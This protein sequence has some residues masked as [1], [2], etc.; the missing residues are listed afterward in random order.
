[1]KDRYAHYRRQL[2]GTPFPYAVVDM[3]LLRTNA[4]RII[5]R[6]A[7]MPV[8][9]ATKSIRCPTLLRFILEYHPTFRGLMCYDGREADY[10][11]QNGFDDIL[12]GY[13]LVERPVM[14]RLAEWAKRGRRIHFMADST[15]HLDL[16]EAAGQA[17]DLELTACLDID[18]SDR[19][20]GLHFGVWRSPLTDLRKTTTVAGHTRQLRYVRISGVMG[21]E[22]QVA[23]VGDA[24]AGQWLQNRVVRLLQRRSI[25]RAAARRCAVVGELRRM[26]YQ[27]DLV[28]GGGTGSME[29]TRQDSSVTELTAGSGFLGGT[30][31]DGYRG[32]R[33][34]PALFYG[35]PVTRRPA[36]GVYTCQGGGYTASG[37]ADRSKAPSVYLP[38]GG[39]LDANEG[40][41]EV[42]TPIRFTP[43][44]RLDLGDPV[45]LRYAKA[46]ELLDRFDGVWLLGEGGMREVKTYRGLR[47]DH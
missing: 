7:G 30:L 34:E 4:D 2:A 42:Q 36:E 19:Y 24:V 33:V 15:A 5:H 29:S 43:D 9:I 41:G 16:L 39:R 38:A 21:Y 44:P 12:M 45:F 14:E 23:G 10:L 31:F 8:R 11:L 46:G 6:A 25:R 27:L 26:G 18:L 1:V 22:A 3:D 47:P 32:F 17:H 35:I 37:V 20:P 40:A 28:N 13:P